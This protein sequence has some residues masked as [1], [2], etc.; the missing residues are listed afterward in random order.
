MGR[1]K[2]VDH[3]DLPQLISVPAVEIG[4]TESDGEHRQLLSA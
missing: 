4:C 1:V 3:P 2:A